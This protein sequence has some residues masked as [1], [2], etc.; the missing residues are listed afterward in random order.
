MASLSIRHRSSTSASKPQVPSKAAEALRGLLEN[1][2]S[3]CLRSGGEPYPLIP[4]VIALLAQTKRHVASTGT[5]NVYQDD[6]R[7]F[8]GFQGLLDVLR[9][10][11]GYY[12]PR[13][14]SYKDM[15]SFFS[16]LEAVLNT[17]AMVLREHPGNKRYFQHQVAGGGWETLE[18]VLAGVGLGGAETQSWTYCQLFG[19]L[20]AFAL[21]DEKIDRVCRST[22]ELLVRDK[23][24]GNGDDFE[25]ISKDEI[26]EFEDIENRTL[27]ERVGLAVGQI[28]VVEFPEPLRTVVGFWESIPR[29]RSST[30]DHSSL[31]VLETLAQVTRVSVFNQA[32]LHSTGALTRFIRRIF[33]VGEQ[34]L[35]TEEAEKALKICKML[36]QGG[37]N[38]P[39]DTQY[40]LSNRSPEAMEF[41]LELATKFRSPPTFHFDL[42]LRGFCSVELS[43]LGR[44][45]PP[46]AAPGYTFTSW[47]KVEKFDPKSHTTIFGVY[48][49]TQTCFLL[50]YLEMDTRN[51]IL[52]TSVTSSKP[53]VRFK[54]V[55][56]KENTWYH[57]ALVHR[58]PKAIS[59]SKASLYVNGEFMEQLRCSYPSSPPFSNGSTESFASFTSNNSK[60]SPVQTFIGTPRDLTNQVGRGVVNSRWSMASAHL[61]EDVLSDDF[62]AVHHALGPRYQGNFQD[63][64]GSFQTYR[65]SAA[66]GLRDEARSTGKDQ[67]SDIV[68]AIRGKASNLLPESKILLSILPT[69]IF[70]PDVTFHDSSLLRSLP[71]IPLQLLYRA[72]HSRE[73]PIAVNAAVPFI[74]DSLQRVSGMAFLIGGPTVVLPSYLD[75]NL[76][77]LGGFTAISL[78]LIER[79]STADETV[80]A[81]E[82][83]FQSI[84]NSWRNS[85][86]MERDCGYGILGM[87]LR[88]KLG[89]SSGSASESTNIRLQ[90]ST[91]ERDSLG[92]RLL[93]LILGFVGYNHLRSDES[94][95][96]NQL[97]YRILL[98]DLDIWRRMSPRI[99]EVYYKQ[100]NVFVVQSKHAVFNGRRLQRMRM[101]SSHPTLFGN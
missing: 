27:E 92:L 2:A 73:Y 79:A 42:S 33:R 67:S 64:L 43:N 17:L 97:A 77:R 44:T 31:L 62:V 86:A 11:S 91:S 37:I 54:S 1:V 40:L 8:R 72:A 66:L 25:H 89:F 23:D 69:A 36:V 53:S 9:A 52:Q 98:I 15:E 57:I 35:T 81:A 70:P 10:F 3:Q 101:G 100:F 34:D 38:D 95:I 80:Q 4:K 26:D 90:L 18:Q 39:A 46:Q 50:V 45:F 87:L 93:S 76:W 85:D 6:F 84:Q 22:S 82:I 59:A 14:R 7:R 12:D 78:K 28:T 20:F 48:D 75:T 68:R 61:I 21:D 55:E 51:F 5:P 99:Q 83:L 30:P 47:I 41:C 29:S 63:S 65:A 74:P 88:L 71:R 19:K 56:F 58:R 60:P 24:G 96:I 16:L 32:A 94:Y 49:S 13:K